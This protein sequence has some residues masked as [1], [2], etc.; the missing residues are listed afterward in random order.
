MHQKI[1]CPI[2][3]LFSELT[4]CRDTEVYTG[5]CRYFRLYGIC[6]L[7]KKK[8][9]TKNLLFPLTEAP[10]VGASKRDYFSNP[11][12][13]ESPVLMPRVQLHSFSV[14]TDVIDVT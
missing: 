5:A 12:S 11:L 1:T 13:R 14:E 4:C 9:M 2:Y 10:L 7:R 3:A 6:T 8:K